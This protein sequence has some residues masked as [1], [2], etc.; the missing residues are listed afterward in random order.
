MQNVYE[1]AKSTPMFKKLE[2]SSLLF[3]EYKCMEDESV[4]QVWSHL[5]YFVY[6]LSGKKQW[7]S[8]DANYMVYANEA[9][10][11]KKGANIIH[12]FFEEDFCAL[13][14]FIPDDFIKDFISHHPKSATGKGSSNND[15]IS[16]IH[17]ESDRVIPLELDS[18]LSTYFQS[19]YAYFFKKK[20]PSSALIE[21]KFKELILNLLSSPANQTV[22]DYFCNI[23]KQ[24][25]PS[26]ESIMEAN[27]TYNLTL[28]DFARLA[29]R[30]LT[31]FKRDFRQCFRTS[32][33]RWLTEK[34]LQY[35]RYL[36]ESTDK[37]VYEVA[38][39]SGFENPSH[40][41]RIFKERTGITPLH[42]KK[43]QQEG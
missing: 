11:V 39:E 14:I 40:F 7:R 34:R 3:T 22:S 12:K 13:M 4:F 17:S 32:P 33:G 27:F 9:I 8:R 31:S 38:F 5:N 36:L 25:K 21:I 19:L 1:I 6:V 23:A 10:F 16:R 30:S 28:A 43:E 15:R 41:T 18:T 26:I 35:A 2:V 20:L 42:F 24:S 37:R 29:Q